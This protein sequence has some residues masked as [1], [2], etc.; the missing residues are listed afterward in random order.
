[1]LLFSDTAVWSQLNKVAGF[2]E[3]IFTEWTNSQEEG[4]IRERTL[5]YMMP[6]SNPM[7]KYMTSLKE[8]NPPTFTDHTYLVR[9]KETQVIGTQQ[10]LQ[11]QDRL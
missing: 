6:V 3:P 1:M 11:E 10:I 2:G 7:G 5:T 8:K 4:V 9:A